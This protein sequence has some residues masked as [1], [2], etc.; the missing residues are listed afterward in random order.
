MLPSLKLFSYHSRGN[1]W[2]ASYWT[3]ANVPGGKCLIPNENGLLTFSQALRASGLTTALAKPNIYLSCHLFLL[4][5]CCGS[6][7]VYYVGINIF[8]K[9][10]I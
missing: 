5:L 6:F 4:N 8:I 2:T 7:L 3:E 9:L 1:L 10:F